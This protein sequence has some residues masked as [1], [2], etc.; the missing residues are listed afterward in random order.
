MRLPI[1]SFQNRK[2]FG[3]SVGKTALRAIEVDR[4][5]RVSAY[6][7]IP[8]PE[9][10]LE[11]NII[12]G[13]GFEDALKKLISTG[14]F[15]TRYVAV[16]LPENFAFSR[17]YT[18]PMTT[19][20]EVHEAINWQLKDL[21]PFAP[22]EIYFDWKILKKTDT[23]TTILIVAAQKKI[24]DDI[25]DTLKSVN[26]RP[27]SFSPSASVL[28]PL[29]PKKDSV[30]LLV[31]ANKRGSMATLV[32][33]QVSFLTTTATYTAESEEIA[34]QKT[35]QSLQQL[36]TY[37]TQRRE[38]TA[39]TAEILVTGE[40]ANG[41]LLS[42]LKHEFKYPV[43]VLQLT[44]VPP[45]YHKSYAVAA[46]NFHR[47]EDTSSINLLPDTYQELY[48]YEELYGKLTRH[49]QIGGALLFFALII[50]CSVFVV[51]RMRLKTFNENVVTL[52][53]SLEKAGFNR[54]EVQ[55][56]NLQA[57]T[58][59]DLFPRK[60]TPEAAINTVYQ[61]LPEGMRISTVTYIATENQVEIAGVSTTRD[62]ILDFRDALSQT[63]EFAKIEVPL[64]SLEHVQ[65]VDFSIVVTLMEKENGK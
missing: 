13:E 44:G 17:E 32:E 59:V 38:L 41:A 29:L 45:A 12:S 58:I 1:F 60:K 15:T 27:V 35:I 46:G 28:G 63:G 56:I 52:S 54:G 65:D 5:K 7:E 57:Q 20:H 53:S 47:P 31:E 22:G 24:I 6:A 33:H 14:K 2:F 37:Y 34:I 8:I 36:I 23:E 40:I 30:F 18:L 19:E 61:L 25:T 39:D 48:D 10:A 55:E 64:S 9:T 51:M 4:F 16:C 50:T 42:A 62:L 26:L 11:G 49:I 21:F 43:A 3:L